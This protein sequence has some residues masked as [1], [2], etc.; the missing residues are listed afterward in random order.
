MNFERLGDNEVSEDLDGEMLDLENESEFGFGNSGSAKKRIGEG[1]L[2]IVGIL[3]VAA[4][5][6]YGMR[7]FGQQS[8]IAEVDVTLEARVNAFLETILGNGKTASAN[9]QKKEMDPQAILSRLADDRTEKQ[10]PI[11]M[12]KKNP[13]EREDEGLAKS[14]NETE[15]DDPLAR[16]KAEI[17]KRYAELEKAAGDMVVTSIM[18]SP[19]NRVAMVEDAVVKI[20]DQVG[21]DEDMMFRVVKIDA[22]NV[23]L[24][25]EGY[26]FIITMDH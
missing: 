6:L 14:Q 7:W 23:V 24:E 13:F 8:G 20:G 19:G 21:F 26:Q 9:D 16:R 15:S 12:V 3:L 10:V 18:G 2:V 22:F 25:S 17:R 1:T 5:A 11:N 4:G